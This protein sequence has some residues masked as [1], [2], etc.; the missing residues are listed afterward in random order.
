M[1]RLLDD[2]LAYARAG[3][4]THVPES[5]NAAE[6]VR[7]V[8]GVLARDDRKLSE[9]IENAVTTT[10]LLAIIDALVNVSGR[11]R[12]VKRCSDQ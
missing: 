1:E 5:I 7:D 6:L 3:R 9:Q 4:T 2:L 11:C 10:R 12:R 8:V